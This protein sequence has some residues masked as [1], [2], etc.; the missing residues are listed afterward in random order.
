MQ[1]R[2]TLRAPVP[3]TLRA[4]ANHLTRSG[5]RG[6]GDSR[7]ALPK[8]DSPG[9]ETVRQIPSYAGDAMT[10]LYEKLDVWQLAHRLALEIYELTAGFPRSEL[11]GLTAQLR[12]AAMAIPTNIVEGNAR[13]HR[14]EYLQYCYIARGSVAEVKY[15]LRFSRDLNL[16][17]LEQYGR[18]FSE[19]DRLGVVLQA[20]ITN[21]QRRTP[22]VQSPNPGIP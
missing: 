8:N 14:G 7:P 13:K 12:R 20:L 17:T 15:L 2:A 6:L 4:L 21:L 18:K 11:Y 9:L 16:I 10:A 19:Y 3:A 22:A 1:S 5:I